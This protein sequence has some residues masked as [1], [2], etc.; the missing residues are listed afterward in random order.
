MEQKSSM[1]HEVLHPKSVT[2]EV[3]YFGTCRTWTQTI[4]PV[5]NQEAFIKIISKK[6]GRVV[7]HVNCLTEPVKGPIQIL[8]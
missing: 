2:L 1:A 7:I 3:P 4:V 6:D 5:S 8:K